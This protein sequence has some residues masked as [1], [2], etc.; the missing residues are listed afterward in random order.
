MTLAEVALGNSRKLKDSDYNASDLPKGHHSTHGVGKNL[1]DQ[2]QAKKIKL[3]KND[4]VVP[5]GKI[6]PNEDSEGLCLYYNEFIVYNTSQICLRY[7]L[8]VEFTA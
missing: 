4:V 1:P 6:V 7:L 3:G 2:K 8:E 5:M